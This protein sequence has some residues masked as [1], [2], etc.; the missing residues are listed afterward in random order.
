MWRSAFIPAK[1]CI[2]GPGYESD[3]GPVGGAQSLSGAW[4][5]SQ[6]VSFVLFY[7]KIINQCIP[8]A[9]PTHIGVPL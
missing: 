2:E 1:L 5:L 3:P 4:L 7:S 6:H 9:V 8:T